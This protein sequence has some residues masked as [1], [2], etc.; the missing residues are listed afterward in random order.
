MSVVKARLTRNLLWRP[1]VSSLIIIDRQILRWGSMW[2]SY[3]FENGLKIRWYI[4]LKVGKSGLETETKELASK[5]HKISIAIWL[6]QVSLRRMNRQ[7]WLASDSSCPV[8]TNPA[9]S[10]RYCD[11]YFFI[12][13]LPSN[14]SAFSTRLRMGLK[15]WR[16]TSTKS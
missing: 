9:I 10:T 2:G 16:I 11:K 5:Q 3:S 14:S 6:S 12:S 7:Q 15:F 1:R 13:R 4:K 8:C